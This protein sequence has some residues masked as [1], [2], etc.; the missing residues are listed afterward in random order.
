MYKSKYCFL[1]TSSALRFKIDFY[2][3]DIS[4]YVLLVIGYFL[5]SLW[6]NY[7]NSCSG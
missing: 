5:K 1:L 4:N 2:G 3:N 7:K 6:I